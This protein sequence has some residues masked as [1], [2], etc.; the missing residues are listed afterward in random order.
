MAF[1]VL[2]PINIDGHAVPS[3]LKHVQ[4]LVVCTLIIR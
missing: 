4:W 1:V 3:A 2:R